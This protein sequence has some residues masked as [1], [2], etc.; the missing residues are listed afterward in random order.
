MISD[1]HSDADGEYPRLIWRA[2][3][4][5]EASFIPD[6]GYVHSAS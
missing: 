4:D 5:H 6:T 1:V 3:D 2:L